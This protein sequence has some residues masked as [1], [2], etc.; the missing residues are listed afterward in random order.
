MDIF[1]DLGQKERQVYAFFLISSYLHT[2]TR[3]QRQCKAGL[4]PD[5]L[6]SLRQRQNLVP[7]PPVVTAQPAASIHTTELFVVVR[8]GRKA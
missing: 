5:L 1:S 3:S 8:T 7:E 2:L 6:S 4:S